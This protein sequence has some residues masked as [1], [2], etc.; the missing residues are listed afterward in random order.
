VSGRA[1]SWEGED[2]GACSIMP[3]RPPATTSSSPNAEIKNA[4]A[5][6]VRY[7]VGIAAAV[8]TSGVGPLR[9]GEG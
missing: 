8:E 5:G 7:G 1:V 6:D 4:E 3:C 9:N 2:F